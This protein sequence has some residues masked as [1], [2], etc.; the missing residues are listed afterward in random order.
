MITITIV[1]LKPI[2]E[3]INKVIGVLIYSC[4]C[5]L[6]FWKFEANTV[7][8]CLFVLTFEKCIDLDAWQHK[9]LIKVQVIECRKVRRGYVWSS[10]QWSKIFGML[11]HIS[12]TTNFPISLYLFVILLHRSHHKVP[13]IYITYMS[14]L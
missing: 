5:Y 8:L 9:T 12:I 6:N 2:N 7:L 1:P 11:I 4:Y 14:S 10:F 3:K 13:V